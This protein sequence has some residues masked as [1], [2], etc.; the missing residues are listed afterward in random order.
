MHRGWT[1][2]RRTI[3]RGND[4][5]SRRLWNLTEKS[6]QYKN[7]ISGSK[8]FERKNNRQNSGNV[9]TTRIEVRN[10]QTI[11]LLDTKTYTPTHL[12]T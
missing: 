1:Q 5:E 11:P 2:I 12:K 9:T 6:T 8:A 4:K 7:V 10:Q 3:L